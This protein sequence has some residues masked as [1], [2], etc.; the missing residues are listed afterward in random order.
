MQ[1]IYKDNAVLRGIIENT[2]DAIIVINDDNKV[3]EWN[4]Y[5][6]DLFGYTQ[7]EAIGRSL[8]SLIIPDTFIPHHE[9]CVNR[10]VQNQK[11]HC[12]LRTEMD[13]RRKDGC[14][15]K[16]ELTVSQITLKD[17]SGIKNSLFSVA[18][19]DITVQKNS[20][21]RV[22]RQAS[23]LDLSRDGIYVIDKDQRLTW[24]NKG[25]ELLYGYSTDEAIGH[26][27]YELLQTD[28]PLSGRNAFEEIF[29][30]LLH[31]GSWEGELTQL[32]KDGNRVT[33][34]SRWVLDIEYDEVLITNTNIT[35]LKRNQEKI[36]Y[37]ATHDD[38]TGLPNRR[39]LE[40]RI[41]HAIIQ[42]ERNGGHVGVLFL[43]LDRFKIINDSLG[44]DM[45]D[46]LLNEV[47][48]RLVKSVRRED[49]VA[50]LGGDEFVVVLEN[51]SNIEDIAEISSKILNSIQQPIS[52][53]EGAGKSI[54]INTSI[55]G[56]VYPKDGLDVITLMRNA[57]LAMY[58]SK[59]YE[60][61]AFRF[62]SPEMNE[63]VLQR[64][65]NEN[66]LRKALNNEEFILHFQ[67]KICSAEGRTTGVEA[68]IRWNHPEKGLIMP[69]EFI[70][71]AEEIGLI[72]K[73]GEWALYAACE[74]NKAWQNMGLPLIQMSV[75]LSVHQLTPNLV[76]IVSKALKM[77][78]LD[79][80][81]LD[82]EV[83][84]SAAMKD[85]D[86]T[87][88][89]LGKL[90]KLGVSISI[91]DFGT[92]YS[93]LEYLKKMP[94]DNLKIDQ[95]FVSGIPTDSNDLCIVAAIIG[96][97]HN[98]KLR[99]IAEGVTSKEQVAFLDTHKCDEMQ[100]YLFSRPVTAEDVE[101]RLIGQVWSYPYQ[102]NHELR[103]CD[104]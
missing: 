75:N 57:D 24:W 74:Q 28:Y 38:L 78:G 101:Q 46:K 27:A 72:N 84:E 53:G 32:T 12:Y 5:A 3:V 85:V 33:V 21:D 47:S 34:L 70:G 31:S 69:S 60:M 37:L 71:L 8:S 54:S 79:P 91:D 36:E 19:R 88:E 30:T 4:K 100:G 14:K 87:I 50:R 99:V 61:G 39:L 10:A 86:M 16:I 66:N 62:Y 20:Q 51:V 22:I 104:D 56:S 55:G 67:P 26:I 11:D 6:T 44:H 82:L 17:Q 92:G 64:L 80:K 45:G 93:S 25:A 89:T 1:R 42:C 7:D 76:N 59:E 81:W 68:L 41:N 103:T 90:R 94:L 83:T 65:T 77:S 58:K 29:Q 40:D 63:L 9:A 18:I 2:M 98:M 35:E 52:L 13:A 48:Q 43:D 102:G 49:T 73:I 97:A 96:L 15:L 23:L 95:S